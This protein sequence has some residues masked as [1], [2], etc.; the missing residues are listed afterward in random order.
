MHLNDLIF[1]PV[2]PHHAWLRGEEPYCC[3]CA[4]GNDGRIGNVYVTHLSNRVLWNIPIYKI[5]RTLSRTAEDRVADLGRLLHCALTPIIIANVV[6]AAKVERKL[7]E[8]GIPVDLGDWMPSR[9][10]YRALTDDD[11]TRC[12]EIID[13]FSSGRSQRLEPRTEAA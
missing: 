13:Q 2:H 1:C 9:T 11:L 3:A 12:R 8:L 10:E 7:L 4:T 6:D 5:G